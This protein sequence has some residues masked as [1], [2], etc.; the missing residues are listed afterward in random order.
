M[1]SSRFL[2][3]WGAALLLLLALS[4]CAFAAQG[5]GQRASLA[6]VAQ[7]EVTLQG[8]PPETAESYVIELKADDASFPMPEG[9][10]DGCCTLTLE[11]TGTASFPKMEFDKLGVYT[12]TIAQRAGSEPTAIQYDAKQ[13]NLK[14]TVYRDE[15]TDQYYLQEALREA[16]G[17]DKT[18]VAVFLNEYE[19]ELTE[20]SV[21][22]IWNDAN[23]QDGLRPDALTVTLSDGQ[24][25]ALN[26]ENDWSATITDIPR[27]EENSRNEIEYTW[28]EEEIPGYTLTETVTEEN[29]TAFTNT[30]IP[31]T[32][33][34]TV[35]KLWQDEDESARPESLIMVLM[36]GNAP[37]TV[38]LNAANNW[39]ATLENLPV[40]RNGAPIQY[41]WLEPRVNGYTQ[42]AAVSE[43]DVTTFT[44]TRN[45]TPPDDREF[46]VTVHYRYWN[47]ETAA[48]SVREIHKVGEGYSITSPSLPGYRCSRPLIEGQQP[49]KHIE[50]VVIYTPDTVTI[51][52]PPTPLGVG[53]IINIGDCLE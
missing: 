52:D 19:I 28:T 53:A 8:T 10:V 41:T 36:G 6:A 5:E 2:K 46:S 7:V 35:R 25:A 22:K 51:T 44:N 4:L 15:E 14:I 30:H 17:E 11:G 31:A 39:E 48:E 9:S 29:A 33:S 40:N 3:L 34:L 21:S 1:A 12:Y 49:A 42:T 38:T 27:F 32:R 20:V 18:D 47:G 43:G 37:Q 26:A 50:F 16:G 24:T 13:Y 23:D 45:Q